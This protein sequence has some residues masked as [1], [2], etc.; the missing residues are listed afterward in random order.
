MPEITI[1]HTNDLHG[2]LSNHAAEI[3][4]REK[5]RSPNVLLLDAGD[6]VASGNIYYRPGGEPVLTL[7]SELG[8]DA[9]AMGNR[10]FHFL[11]P[12][13]KSKISLARF[14]ILAANLRSRS[15][16]LGSSVASS[17]MREV[18][19]LSIAI[20]GLCVP[21][22]TKSMLSSKVS[23]FWFED[24][25]ETAHSLV[26]MLREKADLLIG[27]THIGVQ[28]DEELARSVDGIDL[29]VSG[30][31]HAVMP[32]PKIIGNTAIVQAGWWGHYLG[33]VRI[34]FGPGGR[35]IHG[36]LVDLHSQEST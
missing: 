34:S 24:P 7:M 19:G 25:L 30:H 1:L 3:I 11:A 21:M 6:A 12:G 9:M 33:K 28:A 10:E 18:A 29:I 36:E 13:L 14:P 4:A 2:K 27:L 22:I 23:P 35:E 16:D 31:T 20:F 15:D 5:A 32:E 26:P 8:Y 17:I